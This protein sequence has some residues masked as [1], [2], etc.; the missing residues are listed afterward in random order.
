[1]KLYMY[2]HTTLLQSFTKFELHTI[3]LKM[4]TINL[5]L[6]WYVFW[7]TSYITA[8]T[9]ELNNTDHNDFYCYNHS[10]LVQ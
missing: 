9:S 1:M 5:I 2:N 10:F 3:T 8:H 6:K 4:F 7:V